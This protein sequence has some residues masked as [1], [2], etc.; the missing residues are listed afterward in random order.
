M[1][2]SLRYHFGCPCEG[3]SALFRNMGSAPCKLLSWRAL[4]SRPGSVQKVTL[5]T[6]RGCCT[7]QLYATACVETRMGV[8]A[9][10]RVKQQQKRNKHLQLN[11]Y[12]SVITT[13]VHASLTEW[14]AEPRYGGRCAV[15]GVA[16]AIDGESCS[17]K[18]KGLPA[19]VVAGNESPVLLRD[20]PAT[21]A[22]SD[23]TT[24]LESYGYQARDLSNVLHA[25]GFSV[26]SRA[27][28]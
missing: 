7:R 12:R 2:G 9:D 5:M 14:S 23:V 26:V 21:V 1:L 27:A 11:V 8:Q 22:L 20:L 3:L 28:D 18:T 24:F 6:A 16:S 19:Q 10:T 17:H 13:F 4:C 25:T 15:A